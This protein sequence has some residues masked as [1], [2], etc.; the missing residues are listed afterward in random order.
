MG[1][2]NTKINS[3]SRRKYNSQC[4]LSSIIN[5]S[6]TGTSESIYQE[7]RP[8]SRVSRRTW[9][10]GTLNDPLNS[11]KTAWPVPRF[12]AIFLPEFKVRES[13]IDNDFTFLEFIAKGA[14]GRV[15]KVEEKK[16]K[17]KY[18]LKVISKSRIVEEDSIVQAK[19]EVAIQRAVSHHPFIV[20]STNYWQG[21]KT[22]YI[23]TE[24][25]P[26]GELYYLVKEYEKLPEEVVRIYVAELALAIDFLHNAGI[27]HRDVKASNILLDNEGHALLIDFGLA[28]WLRPLHKT[29]T[30]CGS[31][32]YMA[33]EILRKEQYGREVDWWAL[34]VLMCF[35]L[36]NEYPIT[37][38][39]NG[40]MQ[41]VDGKSIPPGTLPEGIEISNAA[42]DLLHKLLQYDPRTRLKSVQA[43]QRT[44]FYF[45]VDIQSYMLKENSPFRLLGRKS[46]EPLLPKTDYN[47]IFK[48]F[49][50][51]AN[52]IDTNI[53]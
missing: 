29:A 38:T 28:K 6:C 31:Y 39:E 50:S 15:Y 23:L 4:S 7:Y 17:K 14:Y 8:W 26:G 3:Y 19:Q 36:I 37:L 30:F 10:E 24:Y 41:E 47:N 5:G 25:I 35:L 27:V 32:E 1:N 2:S 52:S 33:P 11:T 46:G 48:S 49:D 45:G 22:L 16:T 34:G 18:A 51:I 21:R 44:A 43:M 20:G 40:I 53:N 42:K 12:E 13:P 9:A